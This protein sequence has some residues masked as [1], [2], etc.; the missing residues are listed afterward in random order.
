MALTDTVTMRQNTRAT[1]DAQGLALQFDAV[2]SEQHGQRLQVT[3]NPTEKG[4]TISDHCWVE[5]ATLALIASVADIRM[6]SAASGYDSPSGRSNYAY[7]RLADLENR[8]AENTLQPFE[9]I[10]SVKTYTDM[11]M[12]E[13]TVMRDKNTPLLGRFNMSFRQIVVVSTQTTTYTAIEGP[14][15]RSAS[16]TKNSGQQQPA[17][18]TN[19]Q[20]ANSEKTK[21][22]LENILEGKLPDWIPRWGRNR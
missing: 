19:Q 5:G 20:E 2:I 8:L 6:P 7:Q 9:I 14:P 11:V 13:I 12:T 1:L 15:R 3:E 10:T 18:P 4:V 16:P 17:E 22:D 21:S